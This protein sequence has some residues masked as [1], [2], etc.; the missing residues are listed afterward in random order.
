MSE[1]VKFAPEP[2]VALSDDESRALVD[3]TQWYH[4]FQLRDGLMSKGESFID[5][6]PSLDALG[7]PKDLSGK[8]A[9]DIG[10]WDGPLTFE[11]ERRGAEAMALDI[12]DPERIGFAS[13]RRIIGS[14]AAHYRGSVYQL[15]GKE[16]PPLDL[17]LFRGVYYHLK[18]PL[19][20]FENISSAMKKGGTLHFEGEAFLHYAETLDGAPSGIDWGA[21]ARSEAPVCL[22]YPNNYRRSSNWFVPNAACLRGW[23]IASGFEVREMSEF[24]EDGAQRLYGWAEKVSDQ[25][26]LLEH[27]LY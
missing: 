19:L 17:V 7:V 1:L 24:T 27:P 23:M 8:L 12:Q 11:L 4:L 2:G 5:A 20:A 21:L 26:S 10:A 22:S 18:Y 15:S 9:L 16:L 14:R 3:Q 25:S 13:A 6:G